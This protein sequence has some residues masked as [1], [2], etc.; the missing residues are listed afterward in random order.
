MPM[1]NPSTNPLSGSSNAT[2]L[3]LAAIT[4]LIH[5]LANVFTAYGYFRDELY[6]LACTEHLDIGYVDQPPFSI[7]LLAVNRLLFGDSLFA[8][9]LLPAFAAA[10][11]V[12]LTGLMARE[13][14]GGRFAQI[15]TAVAAIAS[16]IYLGMNGIYSMNCFDIVLW[17]GAAYTLLQLIKTQ[18][19]KYWIVLGVILGVGLLNKISVLW[20][21]AGIAIGMALTPERRWFKTRWPWI[22]G[23]LAFVMFLPYIMWNVQ[24]DFAHLEFIRNAS[25]GKYSSLTPMRFIAGQ[26]L[27]QNPFSLPIWVAGLLFFLFNRDGKAFRPLGIIYIVSFL[28]L[29]IN[30]HSKSEYLSSAYGM[31]FA[32]GGVVIERFITQR[33]WHWLRATYLAILLLTGCVFAPMAMSLLPVET[34]IR[35]QDALGVAPSTPEGKQLEKLPQFYADMFGWEEKAAAVARVFNTLTPEEKAKCAIFADNYGRCAAIDFFGAKYGLPKSIGN[36]NSYWIWGP[37]NTTGEVVIVLG[38]NPEDHRKSFGEVTV[39]DTATC[40]Y[41]M[42]YENYLAISLC[43][44][45]KIPLQ[46]AWARGK[47]YE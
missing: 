23:V 46:E 43:R 18:Q 44:R 7:Y 3:W 2:L 11:T 30:G 25:G 13:I 37:R 29:I 47:H 35:Y 31:L 39:V 14:G 22:A 1:K 21:G 34:F 5:L 8:L 6:Y 19:P 9:R 42:P 32:G 20:L 15:L 40:S 27:L 24:H 16:P 36:H 17:T 12:F 33:G 38:G 26:V 41:C 28:I 10:A 45:L 4:L